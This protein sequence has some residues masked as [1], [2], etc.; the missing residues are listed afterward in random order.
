MLEKLTPGYH[1]EIVQ[2]VTWIGFVDDGASFRGASGV[3]QR[4]LVL[5]SPDES[6]TIETFAEELVHEATHCLLDAVSLWDPLLTGEEAFAEL[7][8]APFRPDPRHLFG[9]F[10]AIVVVSRLIC[11]FEAFEDARLPSSRPWHRVAE[12]YRSSSQS[13]FNGVASYPGMSGVAQHLLQHLVEPVL[14]SPS[15]SPPERE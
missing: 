4:G 1:E 3:T 10:H 9:N 7:H 5:L 8:A 15:T 14:R 11:L 6:W 12:Q 2:L 13:A